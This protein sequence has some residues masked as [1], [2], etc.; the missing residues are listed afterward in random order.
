MAVAQP[1]L[2]V[3]PQWPQAC[4]TLWGAYVAQWPP[5]RE[6]GTT[7]LLADVWAQ[8]AAGESGWASEEMSGVCPGL[9]Q[10]LRTGFD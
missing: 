1:T 3:L 7:H 5:G 6:E 10:F 2:H 4:P 8:E 9:K